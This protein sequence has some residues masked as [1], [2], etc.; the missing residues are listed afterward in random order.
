MLNVFSIHEVK[1]NGNVT[2]VFDSSPWARDYYFTLPR[3][4]RRMVL[5]RWH[6]YAEPEVML[7]VIK[8]DFGGHQKYRKFKLSCSVPPEDDWRR[9][10]ILKRI[11][12]I[13]G[14]F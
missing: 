11:E 2:F 14:P 7:C 8:L 10:Q 3:E 13:L 9:R 1:R 6:E 4:L 5:K 12:T